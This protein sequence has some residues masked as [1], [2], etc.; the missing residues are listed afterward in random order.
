MQPIQAAHTAFPSTS[1]FRA[2]LFVSTGDLTLCPASMSQRLPFLGSHA[3]EK[4]RVE[5]IQE[6]EITDV[7]GRPLECP[8]EPL[9]YPELDD[10]GPLRRATETCRSAG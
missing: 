7:R 1:H 8:S 10:D 6:I 9:L 3:S 5:R 4:C 2:P